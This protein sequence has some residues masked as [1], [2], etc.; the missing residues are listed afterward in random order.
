MDLEEYRRIYM[1]MEGVS[2]TPLN[3]IKRVF[4]L[5]KSAKD[6]PKAMHKD[7]AIRSER[8]DARKEAMEGIKHNGVNAQDVK[9]IA[10]NMPGYGKSTRASI[11][12]VGRNAES[13]SRSVNEM[14]QT[15]SSIVGTNRTNPYD[16]Q[17]LEKGISFTIT[18]RSVIRNGLHLPERMA[19]S[20][21][22]VGH[23]GSVTVKYAGDIARVKRDKWKEYT[24]NREEKDDFER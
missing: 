18:A 5:G 8:K 6:I 9:K 21:M 11:S 23:F 3:A 22:S 16:G 1:N 4:R 24:K 7:A 14:A 19:K 13:V 20:A 17:D 15:S 12:R 2:N 10:K